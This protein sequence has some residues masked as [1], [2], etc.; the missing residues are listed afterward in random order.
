[1]RLKHLLIEIISY[2]IY[3]LDYIL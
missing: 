2:I 1:M 3:M